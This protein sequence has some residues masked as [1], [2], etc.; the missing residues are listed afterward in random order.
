MDVV[1]MNS[2]SLVEVVGLAA[3]TIASDH[4]SDIPS[5]IVQVLLILLAPILFAASIYMFLG[6]LIR[7]SGQ[8]ELSIVRVTWLTKIF[9][10]GDIVCFFIQ[11]SGAAKLVN[12]TDLKEIEAGQNTILGGLGFQVLILIFFTV[13]AAVF[14]WRVFSRPNQVKLYNPSLRLLPMLLSLYLCSILVLIRNLYRLVEY[15]E[16]ANGYLQTNEWPIY[17]FDIVL[18][19]IIMVVS[20]PWYSVDF[21]PEESEQY[22]MNSYQSRA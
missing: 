19:V 17:A 22:A 14:H 10:F 6:R 3:R 4:A 15:K 20:L 16:G 12:T 7:A 5:N 9:V 8:P 2:T 18:M 11:A 21:D 1:L 13:C